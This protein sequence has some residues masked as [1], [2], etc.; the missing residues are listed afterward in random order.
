MPSR[1]SQS[2]GW[3]SPVNAPG[4]W[5]P[6][7][8]LAGRARVLVSRQGDP[9]G[10]DLACA[11]SPSPGRR[12]L[13]RRR[14]WRHD[15]EVAAGEGPRPGQLRAHRAG[16]QVP[17]E[18]ADSEPGRRPGPHCLAGGE[19]GRAG[20]MGAIS[21]S[22]QISTRLC[23]CSFPRTWTHTTPTPRSGGRTSG[24]W[25]PGSSPRC[26]SATSATASPAPLPH[27]PREVTGSR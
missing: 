6:E 2:A 20:L 9:H 25:S 11:R 17:K 10:A 14:H 3:G 16:P 15:R 18:A 22:F 23:L 1:D 21:A 7:A 12:W 4:S 8:G 27:C 26:A 19:P 24:W 5:G 13:C